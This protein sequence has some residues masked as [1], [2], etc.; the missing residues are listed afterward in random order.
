MKTRDSS[1]EQNKLSETE[2]SQK[3]ITR[4]EALNKAG[5]YALSTATLMVL[6]KSQAKASTSFPTAIPMESNS[7]TKEWRRTTRN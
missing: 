7:T 2:G 3:E 5:V 1:K 6:M 4:R